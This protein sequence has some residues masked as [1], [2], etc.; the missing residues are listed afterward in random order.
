MDKS[1]LLACIYVSFGCLIM[2]VLLIFHNYDI[3]D[4]KRRVD[5]LEKAYPNV[6]EEKPYDQE[7]K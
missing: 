5:K 4:L 1:E 3:K 7:E 2:A 6:L